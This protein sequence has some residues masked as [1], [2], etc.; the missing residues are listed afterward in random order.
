MERREHTE[1]PRSQGLQ[2]TVE[3]EILKLQLILL[4]LLQIITA[5]IYWVTS[6]YEAYYMARLI[7]SPHQLRGVVFS[8]LLLWMRKLRST[9]MRNWL[10]GGACPWATLT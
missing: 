5:N 1:A 3:S 6:V 7:Y 9:D 8:P 10:S 2:Q 4:F